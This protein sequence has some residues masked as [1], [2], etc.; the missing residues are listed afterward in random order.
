MTYTTISA[1]AD[2]I[3]NTHN[4]FA[5]M[6]ISAMPAILDRFAAAFD[7]NTAMVGATWKVTT[8]PEY[9]GLNT[10]ITINKLPDGWECVERIDR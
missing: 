8:L 6:N 10:L 2:R 5:E 1:V 3:R 9:G 4:T 7:S